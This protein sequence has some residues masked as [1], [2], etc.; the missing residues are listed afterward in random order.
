MSNDNFDCETFSTEIL[1]IN[2]VMYNNGAIAE[3]TYPHFEQDYS[4][5][6]TSSEILSVKIYSGPKKKSNI[7]FYWINF[8]TSFI[9]LS[10]QLR[11][12]RLKALIVIS[13]LIQLTIAYNA[14][15]DSFNRANVV[16]NLKNS[17]TND[18]F[19]KEHKPV[20]LTRQILIL[21]LVA[22]SIWSNFVLD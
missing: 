4:K 5:L 16:M 19:L 2:S 3:I 9:F 7:R 1:D 17:V 12:S 11:N 22:G 14:L 6:N 21:S 8:I 13:S 20:F 15:G 10:K 18:F